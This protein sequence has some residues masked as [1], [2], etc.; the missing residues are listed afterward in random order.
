MISSAYVRFLFHY[1]TCPL[2]RGEN[3][4]RYN[5]NE[6]TIQRRL[7]LQPFTMEP[8]F[9]NK[10]ELQKQA[11]EGRPITQTEAS[12]VATLESNMTGSGP[13]KGGSAATAQS[14]H[15]KQQNFV[16]TAGEVARKPANEITKEDAAHVQS[17]EARVL[18]GRPPKGSTSADVQSLADENEKTKGS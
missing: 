7:K 17:A 5:T 11:V 16:A 9:P 8:E 13:I 4:N 6:N 1:K 2:H 12:T 14:L 18:G 15:D 3:D 10:S